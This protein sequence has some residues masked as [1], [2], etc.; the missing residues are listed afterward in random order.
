M[1]KLLILLACVIGI[2][3]AVG[4]FMY[5][6]EQAFAVDGVC[7]VDPNAP[8]C[9]KSDQVGDIAKNILNVLSYIV[10]LTA[11]GG[12]IYGAFLYTTS[13][14]TTDKLTKAKNSIMYSVIGL[15]VAVLSYAIV[16]FVLKAV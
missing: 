16:N 3:T 14:G 12:I 13:A 11:V 6:V 2:L 8:G 4:V 1:K 10:G 15:V 9:N 7:Q 5:P